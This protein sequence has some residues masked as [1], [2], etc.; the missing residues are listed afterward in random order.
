MPVKKLFDSSTKRAASSTF[1][2]EFM[3]NQENEFSAE[4]SLKLITSMIETT[5]NSLKDR[6]HYFLLWGWA[7]MIA[8][9]GQYFLKVIMNYPNHY[10]V[11]WITPVILIIQIFL[12]VHDRKVEKVKTFI[13]EVSAYLWTAIGLSFFAAFFIFSKIGWENCYSFYIILYGIGT[14][15]SGSLIKFKPLII[16]GIICF[17]LAAFT[18]YLS[19]DYQIIML[20][21]AILISY[22]IPGH[23]LRLK[24]K[25]QNLV[26][27]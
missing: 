12:I 7:V 22:I 3:E 19:F 6:S 25:K 5:K 11:W 10:L 13:N 9:I 17:P 18:A 2:T 24:H 8:S 23:L 26:N 1:K 27:V 20:A 4:Q 16:G 14:Y 15:V 21:V